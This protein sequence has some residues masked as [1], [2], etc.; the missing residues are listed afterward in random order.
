MKNEY[1][2][3]IKYYEAVLRTAITDYL[4]YLNNNKLPYNL[5]ILNK[6][7]NKIINYIKKSIDN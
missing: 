4:K 6:E 2:F 7:I 3:Q 1:N 5:D